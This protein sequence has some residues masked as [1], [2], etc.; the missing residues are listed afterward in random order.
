MIRAEI[1]TRW[2]TKNGGLIP[3][4][5]DGVWFSDTTE[6]PAPVEG[7]SVVVLVECRDLRN[8]NGYI[9]LWNEEVTN[10]PL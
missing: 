8:V 5:P 4:L 10:G 1:I 3:Q 6:Q 7:Q 2:E 9:V